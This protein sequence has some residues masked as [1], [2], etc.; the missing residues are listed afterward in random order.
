MSIQNEEI[1]ELVRKE[2][3][4]FDSKDFNSYVTLGA[5][6]KG[7]F[8]WR[9][10]AW[11]DTPDLAENIIKFHNTLEYYHIELNDLSTWSEGE[12]GLAWGFFTVN[13]RQKEK[14]PEKVRVRFSYTFKKDS[15]GWHQIMFHRDIQP[16]DKEG[17]CP[18]ELT[19]VR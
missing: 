10:F 5:Y 7:G 14:P 19:M 13:L 11:H 18:I 16:F 3:A 12:V 4:A 2:F 15:Q 1:A 8:G 9:T 17:R 6:I